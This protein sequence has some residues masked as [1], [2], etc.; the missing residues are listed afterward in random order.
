MGC[1]F[2]DNTEKWY[3]VPQSAIV[4]AGTHSDCTLVGF[5]G[6]NVPK[7][8]VRIDALRDVKA[9]EC[10]FEGTV[11]Y[12]GWIDDPWEG[13]KV[14]GNT[15]DEHGFSNGYTSLDVLAPDLAGV[16]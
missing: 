15:T 10:N 7:I 14:Q 5:Q 3:H 9:G 13:R 6:R 2:H 11:V 16:R 8:W 1:D 4:A 12:G